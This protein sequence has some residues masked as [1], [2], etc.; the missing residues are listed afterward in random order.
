MVRCS[1]DFLS[2]IGHHT[3][4]SEEAVQYAHK[5]VSG[6]LCSDLS[7]LLKNNYVHYHTFYSVAE[8]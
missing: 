1:I 4:M 2:H 8:K 3:A 6:F 7:H 5:I